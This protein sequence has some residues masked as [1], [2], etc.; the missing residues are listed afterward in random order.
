MTV[1][2]GNVWPCL[3]PQ[4]TGMFDVHQLAHIFYTI[5]MF[6][7]LSGFTIDRMENPYKM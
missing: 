3:K 6:M 2:P 1:Y 4:G 5:T 7:G